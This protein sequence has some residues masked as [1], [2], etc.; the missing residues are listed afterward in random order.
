M[1]F[2]RLVREVS[3]T[4]FPVLL[5]LLAL[6]AATSAGAVGVGKIVGRVTSTSGDGLAANVI[7]LENHSMGARCD[8]SGNFTIANV[9]VGTYTLKAII[10]GY[11][12]VTKTAVAVDAGKIV[13]VN[14][15]L[16]TEAVQVATV[17][18]SG[19]RSLSHVELKS[20]STKSTID[21]K[22]LKTL[23]VDTFKEA[24][25]IKPGIVAQAGQLHVRGGRSGEISYQVDGMRITDPLNG[26]SSDLSTAAV[27]SSDI[28]IGGLDA[29]YGNAQS[30]VINTRTQ[31]GDFK[32]SGNIQFS[33]DDYGAPDKTFNNFDRFT[34]GVGGP[35]VLPKTT[36]YTTLEGTYSD[37]YLKTSEKRSRHTLL[38]FIRLGDRQTNDL[39]FQSKIAWKP[40]KSYKLTAE[41]LRNFS[42][43]DKY[44]HQWSREGYVQVTYQTITTSS[45]T[46]QVIPAY[47]RW[48][49]TKED[50]TFQYYNAAQHT[51]D[52][53]N[54][55]DLYKLVW[56]QSVGKKSFYNI[57]VAESVF[58]ASEDV[59]GKKPWQYD[60]RYPSYFQGN[61]DEGL[62]WVTHGDYPTY[63][64]RLTKV[65]NAKADFT[66][67]M[68]NH[69]LM[70]GV[71]LSYNDLRLLS[72]DLPNRV[73][74]Q[75]LFGF[76]RSDY[77]YYNPEG[78]FFVQDRWEH[79]GMVLNAGLRYDGYS[80]GN[81]IPLED[82][83]DPKT[84]AL[85]G[86]LRYQWSP[87]LGVAFPVS[88]KDVMS[89]H[90]GRYSQ[91]PDRRFVFE[92]RNSQVR[93]RG[94][95]ALQPE[96]TIAYQAAVQHQFSRDVF[97]QFGVYYKDIFGL[98]STRQFQV[99]DTP[100]PTSIYVNQDY[101]SSRGLEISLEKRLNHH[102]SANM[103]YTYGIATGL[104][105][106]VDINLA[107]QG[108]QLYLPISE[109]PLGYDQRHTFSTNLDIVQEGKWSTNFLWRYGSGFPYSPH[110]QGEKKFDPKNTN[111]K[112]LPTTTYLDVRADRYFTLYGQS[113]TMFL[114]ANNVLDTKN[115]V[116]LEP[117]NPYNPY[118]GAYDYT[119]YYNERGIAGGAYITDSNGDGTD[120]FLPVHDPRVF[121]EGRVLR[122]GVG[123]SF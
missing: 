8:E 27:G 2:R 48:S 109:Q 17:E 81:Q 55:F 114:R 6:T 100:D 73:N 7:V 76:Y 99:A 37:T 35:F 40:G 119:V 120:D 111:S 112:R 110:R 11:A 66:R 29:Q 10:P 113:F 65:W 53:T 83:V 25:A 24:I 38:D 68:K 74:A 116:N 4:V 54:G 32:Y 46:R 57:K 19:G 21:S 106:D 42:R 86:R 70:S 107:D 47:G 78:S 122:V 94:N 43:G 16:A 87:R 84:K 56:T 75:G 30:G 67:R 82:L 77:H 36:F 1:V 97:M 93:A 85:V 28:I 31:E 34:L 62:F 96:T 95:P 103:S 64:Q 121:D 63:L 80:V 115:I 61:S 60:I 41:V 92:D 33:T 9:P 13:T 101:A 12:R 39:K 123:M 15:S 102:F 18:V 26:G 14:F 51:P 117:G 23:P 105:S 69:E 3:R 79:E 91:F 50:S 71:E 20:S 58:N 5:V 108:N 104:A 72:V 118:I 90:Y 52:Y 22:S 89:F 98:L 45:G 49:A 44:F 88:D 59:Q